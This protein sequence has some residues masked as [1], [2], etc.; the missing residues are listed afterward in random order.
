V[1]SAHPPIEALSAAHS[2]GVGQQAP[3]WARQRHAPRESGDALAGRAQSIEAA[4][5]NTPATIALGMLEG[6]ANLWRH[7]MPCVSA[8]RMAIR[9]RMI[10][11]S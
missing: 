11:V 6:R 3:S 4:D 8:I 2:R 1:V 10:I 9:L 5:S 7:L